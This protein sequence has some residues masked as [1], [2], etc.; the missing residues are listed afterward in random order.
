M[1]QIRILRRGPGRP[2][3]TPARVLADKAYSLRLVRDHLRRRG[4]KMV[5][6][7]RKDQKVN[8]RKRGSAGGR[9]CAFDPERYKDRNTAETS[10]PQCCHSRGCSPSLRAPSCLVFIKAA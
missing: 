4:I 8:R 5:I 2:R 7:E 1:D 10:K 6:P 3:L 9:P